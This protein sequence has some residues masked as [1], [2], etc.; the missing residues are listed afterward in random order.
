MGVLLSR[1]GYR[2]YNAELEVLSEEIKILE[3]ECR[4]ISFR[5]SRADLYIVLHHGVSSLFGAVH[6]KRLE[7]LMHQRQEMLREVKEKTVYNVAKELLD[8]Y[9]STAEY[10]DGM[11]V[12]ES[13]T[14]IRRRQLGNSSLCKSPSTS[15]TRPNAVDTTPSSYPSPSMNHTPNTPKSSDESVQI[16]PKLRHWWEQF[17][18]FIVRDGPTERY[19]L[20][21]IYCKGHNGMAMMEDFEDLSFRCCYCSMLNRSRGELRRR[22]EI[23]S[24][25]P[26]PTFGASEYAAD[27]T[28]FL[29]AKSIPCEI[30]R[31]TK[32]SSKSGPSQ[33]S[34]NR[35]LPFQSLKDI[36]E[37]KRSLT[38]DFGDSKCVRKKFDTQDVLQLLGLSSPDLER[39]FTQGVAVVSNTPTPT[40]F[41]YP[42]N[43]TAEQEQYARGF[44]DALNQIHQMRGFVPMSNMLSPGFVSNTVAQADIEETKRNETLFSALVLANSQNCTTPSSSSASASSSVSSSSS[45]ASSG[46][47]TLSASTED[48][49]QQPQQQQPQQQQKQEQQQ[50]QQTTDLNPKPSTGTSRKRFTRQSAAANKMQQSSSKIIHSNQKSDH[51]HQYLSNYDRQTSE[52]FYEGLGLHGRLQSA[53]DSGGS[54]DLELDVDGQQVAGGLSSASCVVTSTTQSPNSLPSTL[55]PMDLQEQERIKLERKRARNRV[56]ATKCRRRKLEKITEL[57]SRVSTLTAQNEA[58]MDSI[59][60]ISQELQ[61]LQHVLQKHIEAGCK[62]Q[63]HMSTSAVVRVKEESDLAS[64]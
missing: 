59:R 17:M 22:K 55:S 5:R 50:Q 10:M 9:D 52:M 51:T 40:Q 14:N 57:E 26:S 19:A 63:I 8:R 37:R 27:E 49:Q 44:I 6:S 13:P 35:P 25:T 1:A 61:H 62:L 16:F 29:L 21:C 45:S 18:D 15:I 33:D 46:Q 41:F 12:K 36:Q 48:Q 32:N 30:N 23:K 64:N 47:Q 54:F 20:I 56:A 34:P 28:Y 43:V 53:A 4:R 3:S 24:S 11:A 7:N 39:F 38:L 2:N 31:N 42:K 58:Y 60:A